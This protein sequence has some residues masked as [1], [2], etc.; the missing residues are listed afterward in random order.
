MPQVTGYTSS[1]PVFLTSRKQ[2]R[3][4]VYE[5][6]SGA[7]VETC[8]SSLPQDAK[9][10]AETIVLEKTRARQ[11]SLFAN[12]QADV[13]ERA[14][15]WIKNNK[16]AWLNM[17]KM[18]RKDAHDSKY[19]SVKKYIELVREQAG[20]TENEFKVNNDFAPVFARLLQKAEPTAR[21][22]IKRRKSKLDAIELPELPDWVVA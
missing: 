14:C 16:Q 10:T 3:V 7:L 5:Y 21:D 12:R 1:E 13:V 19:I 18:A 6:P 11:M 9:R 4:D 17:R 15:E 8:W 22:F 2:Y 20:Y